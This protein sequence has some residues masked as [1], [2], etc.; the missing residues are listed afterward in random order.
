MLGDNF[1]KKLH[2]EV[3]NSEVLIEFTD[4]APCRS[5]NLDEIEHGLAERFI[6][7]EE[8]WRR[9]GKQRLREQKKTLD[10]RS[11]ELADKEFPV[12]ASWFAG[13][14]GTIGR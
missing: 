8:A 12:H 3:L 13:G 5:V 4:N 14:A 10:A 6:K 9:V 2:E 7:A 1:D 11:A